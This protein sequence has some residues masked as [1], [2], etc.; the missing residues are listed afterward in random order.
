[1]SELIDMVMFDAEERMEKAIAHARSE[2]S[3]IRSNHTRTQYLLGFRVIDDF[4]HTFA[5]SHAQ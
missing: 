3:G 4:G 2:F 1:M 5:S